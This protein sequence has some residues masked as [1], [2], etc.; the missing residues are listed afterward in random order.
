[1]GTDSDHG[2]Q[3]SGHCRFSRSAGSP[4]GAGGKMFKFSRVLFFACS[5]SALACSSEGASESQ[6][7][8]VEQALSCQGLPSWAIKS[9]KA[10]EQVANRGQAYACKPYPFTGWCG[11]AT[12]YEPGVGHAWQDARVPLGTCDGAP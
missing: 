4:P 7:G 11:L 6:L 12:A 8:T 10:G 9:Y 3:D 5:W 1:M 2:R